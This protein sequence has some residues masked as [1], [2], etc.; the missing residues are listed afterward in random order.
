MRARFFDMKAGIC[1]IL[2]IRKLRE[3]SGV[4]Q[5]KQVDTN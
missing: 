1:Y 4:F 5:E 2:P 3:S